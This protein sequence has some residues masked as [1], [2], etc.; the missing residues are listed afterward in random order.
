M[1]V[2]KG[3]VYTYEILDSTVILTNYATN[4]E[5]STTL[6]EFIKSIEKIPN[7]NSVILNKMQK[8]YPECF[9]N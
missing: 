5:T 2:I 3:V 4:K 6:R 7:V 9:I 8:E 1:V